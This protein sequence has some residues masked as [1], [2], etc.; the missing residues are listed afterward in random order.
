MA[1]VLTETEDSDG[2]ILVSTAPDGEWL[3]CSNWGN[4]IT[5]FSA[6]GKTTR[7]LPNNRNAARLRL[8]RFAD[9]SRRLATFAE[10]DPETVVWSVAGQEVARLRP[11]GVPRSFVGNDLVLH[12]EAGSGKKTPEYV[13]YRIGSREARPLATGDWD[14]DVDLAGGRLVYAKDRALF[15]RPLGPGG[16]E[17]AEVKIGEHD[18]KVAGVRVWEGSNRIVSFDERREVRVWDRATHRLLRRAQGLDPDRLFNAPIVDA[19]GSFLAWQSLRERA[20]PVWDLTGPPDSEPLLLHNG[21]VAG[22]VGNGTFTADRRWLVTALQ[23][24]VALWPLGMKRPYVIRRDSGMAWIAF[25]PDSHQ[26]V[27]C[28]VN[29]TRAYPLT[30]D[31]PTGH[32]IGPNSGSFT[33]YGLAMEP[34]GKQ[35]LLAATTWALWLAP[36]DGGQPQMLVGVSPRESIQ[37][38][39]LDSSGRWAATAACYAPDRKD[40]L[41]HV[42]DR[43]AAT[44]RAF[45]LPGSAG[46]SAFSGGAYSL[47]FVADGRL[48]SSSPAGLYR[49]D[50]DSGRNERLSHAECGL[51]DGSRDGRTIVV[52]CKGDKLPIAA[53]GNANISAAS[54]PT[55]FEDLLV[56]DTT[57]GGRRKITSHGIDFASLAVSP[58]GDFV[59]TGDTSGTVRVGRIDGSEPHLLTGAGGLLFSVA[60]SPDGKWIASSSGSEIRLWPM[61]DLSQPPLHTLPREALLAKLG[62]LTNVRVVEDKAAPS[63]Y[64][65]DLAPFPGWK[66]VPTW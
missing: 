29:F 4:V 33:C 56:I 42:F 53:A 38:V 24:K 37:A 7:L 35:V 39:A 14:T 21:G 46:E 63:G 34:T 1:R 54:S 52:A 43:R 55:Q 2:C 61:P 28:G 5:L 44:A 9:D 6:D 12:E 48:L 22:D 47:R 51:M 8:V 19:R 10:G 30:A 16:A 50:P 18:F 60:F 3:A 41:L 45:P 17:R 62:S 64:K 36:M 40:R 27:S 57:T 31:A 58:S 49:W 25:T 66:D 15:S 11:G 32:A 13:A 20:F 26:I 23:F 59:A 65:V